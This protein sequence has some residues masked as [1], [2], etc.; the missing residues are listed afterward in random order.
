MAPISTA[1][2]EHRDAQDGPEAHNPLRLRLLI[3]GIG[4]DIEDLNRPLL[5]GNSPQHGSAPRVKL[6][7][8]LP[9][10]SVLR[11][12]TVESPH[13][14]DRAVEPAEVSIAG[15]A[16][17][18]GVLNQ[19]FQDRLEIEW[20]AVDDLEDL[21]CGCLLLQG[22]RQA[23]LELAGPRPVALPRQAARG[24]GRCGRSLSAF[25]TPRHGPP[26][27]SAGIGGARLRQGVRVGKGAWPGSL[28]WID[29]DFRRVALDHLAPAEWGSPSPHRSHQSRRSGGT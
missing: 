12:R 17:L 13:A 16:E 9:V 27:S 25:G 3:L 26:S 23:L 20:R 7:H 2:P 21:A 15:V 4:Q 18:R 1:P 14:K 22:L 19:G 24:R 10:V 6:A 29:P 5:E 8:P 11:G 28:A